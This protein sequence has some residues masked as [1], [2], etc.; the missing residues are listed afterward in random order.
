MII[1]DS[2]KREGLY[3]FGSSLLSY[4]SVKEYFDA[5]GMMTDPKSISVELSDD[6]TMVEPGFFERFPLLQDLEIP[7]S[8]KDLGLTES[9]K[10]FLKK[11]RVL[12]RGSFDSPAEKLARE[13][14]LSFCHTG[15]ELGRTGDYF[16][17]GSYLI[18]LFL[19]PGSKPSIH[20][21]SFHV[22]SSAGS[23]YG[24]DEDFYL[25]KDFYWEYTPEKIAKLCWGTCYNEICNNPKLHTFLNKARKRGGYFIDYS[26]R[27][28]PKKKAQA[29]LK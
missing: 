15:F 24:T 29:D 25:P 11:R 4:E 19:E 21:S 10:A 27:P 18:G 22:G 20:Q 12:L 3:I 5:D 23:S 16:G 7:D 9:T 13:L 28:D 14:G 6:I 1:H 26:R 2:S 8:V 17:H